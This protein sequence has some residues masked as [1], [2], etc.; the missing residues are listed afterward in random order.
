[1]R[2][3][4]TKAVRAAIGGLA[5]ALVAAQAAPPASPALRVGVTL[6]P[7]YSWVVNVVEGTG[8][9]VRAVLP[10]DVDAGSYQPRPEDVKKLADLDAIVINGV[11]H[12]DFIRGMLGASGNEKVV[13]LEPS[14]EVPL[15]RAH[16][17]GSGG[18]AVNSH[19]FLS[20]TNAIQ[21]T[22]SIAKALGKLRPELA[23][24][25]D[26]SAAEYAKRLRRIK[27]AAATKLADAAVQR[28][29]TV[30]DGYGY[31][32]QEFGIEVAGV[33]EPAHGLVPSAAELQQTIDL[34]RREKVKVLFSEASFPEPLLQVL[35]EQAGARVHVLSHVATGEYTADK[36]EKE[37]QGNVDEI[38]RAL[39][40]E[41]AAPRDERVERWRADVAFLASELAAKHKN[42]FHTLPR[43]EWEAQVADLDGR[44][45]D[46][47][48]REIAVEIA[49]LVASVGDAH[50][51]IFTGS[52][53]FV[54]K[55]APIELRWFPDGVRLIAAPG[56]QEKA[57]GRRVLSIGGVPLEEAW[58]R[59]SEVMSHENEAWLRAQLPAW[60]A[61]PAFLHALGLSDDDASARYVVEPDD[62]GDARG[63]G[64]VV[65]VRAGAAIRSVARAEPRPAPPWLARRN[66]SYWFERLD[67]GT[68]LF[69]QYNRCAN[70]PNK[71]FADLARELFEDA[72]REA[73]ARIV[74]D[75]RHNGGG[76]SQVIQPLFAGLAERRPLRRR[77]SLFVAIGPR[78]FSSGMMNAVQLAQ[79]FGA[80]LVGEPTGGKPNGYGEVRAL[81]LPNS[82]IKVSYCTKYFQMVKGDPESVEPDVAA[83]VTFEDWKSGR[84]PALAAILEWK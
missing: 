25:F 18:G 46:L 57:V 24:K 2:G 81:E 66:E 73:P 19:T 15:L 12:D 56:D 26:E 74:V 40:A 58:K 9:E 7:Y 61:M 43:E 76:D 44:L 54:A 1:M 72:D 14:R 80:I 69:L 22:Y 31:L 23:A 41:P 64:V 55:G 78:T 83:P 49:R 11:G 6:H 42:L 52:P 5:L 59:A 21:Q 36:F 70:D 34:I 38:V 60:L 33:V 48:D 20:F 10:G 3:L 53:P 8:V 29:V 30:H 65:D 84:D 71:P 4:G 32:L 82:K 39:V 79:G 35:R 28:V 67:G 13:V 45:A 62:E 16:R 77:G 50:T 17:Q 47:E 68:T 27:A 75:L 37:M 63:A 51:T